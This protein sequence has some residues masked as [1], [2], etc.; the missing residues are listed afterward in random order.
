MLVFAAKVSLLTTKTETG[1]LS[2]VLAIYLREMNPDWDTHQ[3]L[4]KML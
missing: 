3:T 2:F 4:I 1:L